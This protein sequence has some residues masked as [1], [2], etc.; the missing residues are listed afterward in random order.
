MVP[1][2]RRAGTCCES[3]P[4]GALTTFKARRIEGGYSLAVPK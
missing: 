2:F 4:H 1:T 3:T